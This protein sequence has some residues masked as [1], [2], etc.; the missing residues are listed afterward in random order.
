MLAANDD[1]TWRDVQHILLNTAVKNAPDDP[2][3]VTNGAGHEYNHHYA[4]GRLD[5]YAAVQA[6]QTWVNVPPEASVQQTLSPG[7]PVP[8]DDPAG[9]TS[10]ITISQDLRLETVEIPVNITTPRRGDLRIELESPDGTVSVLAHS[11]HDT[12]DDY[13]WTFT[14]VQ[15]WDEHSVGTWTLRVID[16]QASNIAM[17]NLWTLRVWGTPGCPDPRADFDF[18]C[19]VDLSDFGKFALCYAGPGVTTPPPS[20]TDLDFYIADVDGDSDVDLSDFATFALLY[21]S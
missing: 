18:D 17:L 9:L 12:N 15:H 7:L 21:S 14:S 1:L 6:A 8:D 20:C 16:E 19:D 13:D 11:N 10:Q 2:G 5:A 4:F 3:W